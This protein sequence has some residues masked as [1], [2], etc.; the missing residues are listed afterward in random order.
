VLGYLI[1][2]PRLLCGTIHD[3]VGEMIDRCKAR[4]IEFTSLSAQNIS[5]TVAHEY[6]LLYNGRMATYA[7][8][9][10]LKRA[11]YS[12]RNA[13]FGGDSFSIIKAPPL[14]HPADDDPRYF[15][16]F[17]VSFV[18]NDKIQRMIGWAN[19][20]L[21]F[22]AQGNGS[23]NLF[24]DCTFKCVVHGFS[25]LMILMIHEERTGLYLPVF[26]VLLQSNTYEVYFYALNECI[27]RTNFKM[28]ANSIT[29]DF[30]LPLI[31]ALK[32]QFSGAST[33]FC[34]FHWKQA[35]RRKLIKCGIPA[36][37]VSRL[38][39]Q[40]DLINILPM[41]PVLEIPKAIAYIRFT[42]QEGEFVSLFN[43]FWQYFVK[44]WCS[45]YN[46]GFYF[47]IYYILNILF[48]Y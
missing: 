29:C 36:H 20:D 30:E 41:V 16:A 14:A 31:Q 32:E 3:I 8:R 4:A 48:G 18:I 38:M 39:D 1:Y 6:D 37:V 43:V 47:F 24:V 15:F 44:T 7:T 42:F 28:N 33:I 10:Q 45:R 40:N 27:A 35:V 12:A 26:F 5:D 34:F 13:E 22:L 25:Q 17:D 46:P 23:R 9:D 19:P 11:V 21:L 2:L